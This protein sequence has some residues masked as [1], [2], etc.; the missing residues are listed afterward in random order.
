VAPSSGKKGDDTIMIIV[1]LFIVIVGGSWAIWL[2][3]HE[4][5]L[6]ALR[7]L[8]V[9][10]LS[11]LGFFS[12]KYAEMADTLSTIPSRALTTTILGQASLIVGNVLRW[13]IG[14]ALIGMAVMAT[15]RAPGNLLR[16]QYGIESFISQQADAFPIITPIL[17]FNP[18]DKNARSPGSP[19]PDVLPPFAEALSPEEWLVFNH[20]PM[21]GNTPDPDAMR[22]AMLRD[23][24][25]RWRGPERMPLYAQCLLAAF[26]LK[27]ICKRQESDDL[28]G[29][30]SA[31]WS[32]EKGLSV[33]GNLRRRITKILKD[34][35]VGGKALKIAATHAYLTTAMMAVLEWARSNGGV[36]APA[37]FLWLRAVARPLWYPL[38]NLGRHSFHA[39]AAASVT[40]FM[41]EQKSGRPLPN[42]KL[43]AAIIAMQG[44]MKD[45]EIKLPPLAAAGRA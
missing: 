20:I 36:L 4:Q 25:P 15:F 39:E 11:M 3:G 31:C 24:G 26:A 43:D 14:L 41:A 38:N 10:E 19:V 17:K 42:P 35:E 2:T 21:M 8:K 9:G 28:L 7:W 33:P 44:Y 12:P 32:P 1:L 34:P 29:E 18:G 40:H 22:T 23:I 45:P 6:N 5:I 27:G 13:P 37:Q 30:I 16:R